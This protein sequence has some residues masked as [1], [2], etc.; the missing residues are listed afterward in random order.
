MDKETIDFIVKQ[1][2][3]LKKDLKESIEL[4]GIVV[5]GTIRSE[6]N[7]IDEMDKIRNGK[8]DCNERDIEMLQKETRLS[9]WMQRNPKVAII[10]LIIIISVIALGAYQMNIKPT[11][12]KYLR[13]EL[14]DNQ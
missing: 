1:N 9:R 11:I 12:E 5:R 6:V 10:G 8:I 7:R 14:H 3:I 2:Q 13:I 4:N